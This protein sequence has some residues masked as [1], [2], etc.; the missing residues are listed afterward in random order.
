V[1]KQ[2]VTFNNL[3]Q[4]ARLISA[5]RQRRRIIRSKLAG[6]VYLSGLHTLNF[7]CGITVAF[8]WCPLLDKRE[9]I[10][11]ERSRSESR[12]GKKWMAPF[13]WIGNGT[14]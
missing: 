1:D 8:D 6:L 10:H 4:S 7:D 12:R 5:G 11:I 14:I 9:R 13:K 3:R 2:E